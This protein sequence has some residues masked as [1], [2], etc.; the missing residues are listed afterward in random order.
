MQNWNHTMGQVSDEDKY[1]RVMNAND[2]L[3]LECIARPVLKQKMF[4]TML[5]ITLTRSL[6]IAAA[7]VSFQEVQG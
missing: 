7:S 2:W 4:P 1:C 6:P 3:F 5:W